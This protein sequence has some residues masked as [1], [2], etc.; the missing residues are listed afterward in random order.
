VGNLTA[1]KAATLA[2]TIIN[3]SNGQSISGTARIDTGAD[4]SCIDSRL[5]ATVQ[6]VADN[7][8]PIVGINSQPTT[9]SVY[10]LDIDLGNYGYVS[11]AQ[12]VAVDNLS[13][14]NGYDLLI[15]VDILGGG[16]FEYTG[17]AGTF[18]LQLGLAPGQPVTTVP[19]W[20]LYGG[21]ATTLLGI[22]AAVWIANTQVKGEEKAFVQGFA[23]GRGARY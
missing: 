7:T 8:E 20:L 12:L 16:V 2:F 21:I 3:T 13:A 14:N 11:G 1:G 10:Q 19:D 17:Y 22:T 5:P 23:A 15:G 6:A 4:V 18:D 9:E